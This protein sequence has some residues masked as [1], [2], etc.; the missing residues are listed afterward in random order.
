M[1]EPAS[2]SDW[3]V[4]VGRGEAS[5]LLRLGID[6]DE[7]ADDGRVV[8]PLFHELLAAPPVALHEAAE[9]LLV[10]GGASLEV[11]RALKD[12]AQAHFAPEC[13]AAQ[14]LAAGVWYYL[15]IA[16]ARV[17]R[18][19]L[20]TSRPPAEVQAGLIRLAARVPV[21]WSDLLSHA[22]SLIEP[23]PLD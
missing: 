9:P 4:R 21:P 17:H 2:N 15:A 18:G 8:R 22:A 5:R 6:R 1:S 11:L 20:L 23:P 10:E 19:V 12:A 16:A 7:V 14:R 3:N 13:P